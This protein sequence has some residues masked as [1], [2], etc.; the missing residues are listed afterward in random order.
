MAEIALDRYEGTGTGGGGPAAY[1]WDEPHPITW[2]GY[3]APEMRE[4][5]TQGKDDPD[6]ITTNGLLGF[7]QGGA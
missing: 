7:M 6:K 3:L 4:R 1:R 2:T 5:L